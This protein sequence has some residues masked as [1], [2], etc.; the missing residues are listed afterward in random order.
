[1]SEK[2]RTKTKSQR[3]CVSA[4]RVTT[5]AGHRFRVPGEMQ[6]LQTTEER[7]LYGRVVSRKRSLITVPRAEVYGE[8]S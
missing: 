5:R 8:E 4:S 3:E 1:M 6:F 2:Q 7:D